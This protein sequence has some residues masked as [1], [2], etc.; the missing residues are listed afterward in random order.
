[1]E[2]AS[3][4]EPRE[5]HQPLHMDGPPSARVALVTG[6]ASGIGA[7]VAADLHERG[8]HVAMLDKSGA[9]VRRLART[10]DNAM[11][12]HA[13]V[14]DAAALEAAV[15]E[16]AAR[17]HA[18]DVLVNNAAV[19]APGS[20]WDVSIEE[21]DAVMAAN[22]RGVLLLTRLCAARMRRNGWGRV[23]NMT[24]LAGQQG[25][26]LMGPHYSASKAGL[27]VLTKIFAR[28]LAADGVTVNAVAPSSIE[29]PVMADM[30]QSDIERL[31][32]NI[33]VQRL[34]RPAEVA[35]LVAYL[36][37]DEAGYITGATFDINGG[38]FM[39]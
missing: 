29:T 13:D 9:A 12:L 6:A 30:A 15:D 20:V 38:S 17:W 23:I 1:M 37:T 8:L 11:A 5:N 22:L 35:A 26:H 10:L 16:V 14:S 25:G 3:E 7:A 2:F 24:S 34:G 19:S 36:S 33:P 32:R 18:P 21:W 28:E 39:R 4:E 31:V 27:L